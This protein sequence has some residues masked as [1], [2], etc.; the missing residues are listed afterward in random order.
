MYHHPFTV[1]YCL[2]WFSVAVLLGIVLKLIFVTKYS[3]ICFSFLAAVPPFKEAHITKSILDRLLQQDIVYQISLDESQKNE[4]ALYQTGIPASYFTLLLE[5][6]LKVDIGKECLTFDARGFYFFG[7]QV[8]TDVIESKIASDY[9]PDFTVRPASDCLVLLITRQ[10]YHAA[11]RASQFEMGKI[12]HD[13]IMNGRMDLFSEE[14]QEAESQ[15]LQSSL[16]GRP[17]LMNIKHLLKTK[18]LQELKA[19][20]QLS[21][22]SKTPIARSPR[23]G[24]RILAHSPGPSRTFIIAEADEDHGVN[25]RDSERMSLLVGM[26]GGNA[27]ADSVHNSRDSSPIVE[28]VDSNCKRTSRSLSDLE[29]K[30]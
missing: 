3:L 6:C 24:L 21:P 18:P 12:Q 1:H 15:D 28:V 16:S 26:E 17:G 5:G 22:N 29:T 11:Y 25:E 7:S 19:K 14:W 27:D 8:L 9:I 10:R 13:R 4:F 23:G 30:F 2:T 20:N